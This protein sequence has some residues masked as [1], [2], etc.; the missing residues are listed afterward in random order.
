VSRRLALR[1]EHQASELR[2]HDE[3]HVGRCHACRALVGHDAQ[4]AN[5]GRPVGATE[6]A[7]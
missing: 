2:M 1:G 7:R 4:I 3:L 6:R 5:D